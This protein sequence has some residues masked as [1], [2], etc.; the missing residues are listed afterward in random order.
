MRQSRWTTRCL[1]LLGVAVLTAAGCAGPGSQA[2]K[3]DKGG[4]T[5]KVSVQLD[6]VPRGNHSMFHVAKEKGYFA[7][8]GI[9]VTTIRKGQGSAD[10]MRMVGGKKADFGF[11]DLPTLVKARTQE[12]PV[13]ALAA[14]NQQSPLAMCT[15]A[16]KHPLR[17]PKDLDGLTV[18]IHPGQSTF[19]FYQA[20]LAANDMSRSDVQ[21]RSLTPPF[22][23]YLVQDRV[24]A[25]PC[26]IDAEVPE[27]EPK[28]GGEKELSMLLGSEHG[29]DAYGSGLFTNEAMLEKDPKLVQ[30]FVRAYLKAFDFVI[31]QPDEAAKIL[32]KSAP[33]LSGKED[34]FVEQ[35]NAD[36]EHTF[37]SDVTKENGLGYMTDEDWQTTVDTLVNQGVVKKAPKLSDI[38][39]N[40]FVRKAA[41]KA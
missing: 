11:G 8:E 5:D 29:Y 34:V 33:E 41:V 2:A 6:Y 12:T 15:K 7:K 21:E 4:E 36:I 39:Q 32:A 10:A 20:L 26:Y 22:T 23:N 14:V 40:R 27:L 24:D 37:T 1:A 30:R 35:L 3:N 13:V 28:I 31:K 17:S 38:Y 9:E 25:I 18:G 19:V 16:D